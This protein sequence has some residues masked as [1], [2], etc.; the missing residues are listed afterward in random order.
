[1]L[2]IKKIILCQ[3]VVIVITLGLGTSIVQADNFSPRILKSAS[4]LDYPPFALVRP[5]GSADGFSVDLLKAITQAVDLEVNISVDPWHK[6]KRKLEEGGLDVLP[7]VSYS[8]E[9]DKMLD[10]TAPY[11]KMHGT[12]FVRK[13]E[14]SIQSKADLNDK[15]VLVMRSDAAHEYAIRENLSNKLILTDSFEEAMKLLSEGKHDAVISQHLL[16]LQLIKKLGISNVVSVFAY[17]DMNLKPDGK[18]LEGFEQKFCIAVR[19]GEAE[20]LAHLNEGLAIVIANGTY[21][22]LYNNW[23]GAIIPPQPFPITL[24]IKYLSLI[25]M[26]ILSLLAS[27]NDPFL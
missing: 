7:L 3:L 16:G 20:L 21:Q 8:I 9:R 22:K 25:L 12:I 14:K 18:R 1:M 2:T 5:D 11:L 24:I 4:E 19:E 17:Q 13:G 23:F 10:F 15:A 6:I 27:V 26:P